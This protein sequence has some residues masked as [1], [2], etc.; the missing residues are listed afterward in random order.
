MEELYASMDDPAPCHT[1]FESIGYDVLL[2]AQPPDQFCA[3]IS[4]KFNEGE[5]TFEISDDG[6]LLWPGDKPVQIVSPRL[7]KDWIFQINNNSI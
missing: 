3:E 7:L 1:N 4:R 6:V 5:F 2:Q